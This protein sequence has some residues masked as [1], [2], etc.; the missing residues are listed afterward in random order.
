VNPPAARHPAAGLALGV[1]A[2]ALFG[3]TLPVTRWTL[4]V[5]STPALSPL[6]ITFARV[7]LAAGVSTLFLLAVRARWPRRS[8]CWPLLVAAAGNAVLYPLSLALALRTRSA[9]HV[10]VI[11]AL[12]PL[13]TA[14]A[15][16]VVAR[17]NIHSTGGARG[18]TRFWVCA[19]L[20]T[21][22]VVVFSLQREAQAGQAFGLAIEDLWVAGGVIAASVGYV[23]G[24]RVTRTMGA[25]QVICWVTLFTLP[26]S[27]P[28]ALWSAPTGPVPAGAWW[29]LAYLALVSM[30]AAFF[31][32]YRALDWGGPLRVSQ[33]QTFQPF[34]SIAF[35]WPL[36]GERPDLATAAFAALVVLLVSIGVWQRAP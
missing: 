10:A 8:E 32:W 25:E 26:V 35:A 5:G 21:A 29:G 20:G 28:V 19:L 16:V 15:A 9:A 17:R 6:F 24:A 3:A 14:A 33:L 11:T 13:A 34:F 2:M 4:G 27:L 22:V 12:L 36:L 1:L 30:W 7:V 31:A 23:H 18:H